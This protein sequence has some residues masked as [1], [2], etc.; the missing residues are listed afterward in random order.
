M[1]RYFTQA[2]PDR[3]TFEAHLHGVPFS[4][5]PFESFPS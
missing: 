4:G 2:H 1:K 3:V 5:S